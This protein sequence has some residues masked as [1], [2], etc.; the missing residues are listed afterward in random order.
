MS[1]LDHIGKY[2]NCSP[3]LPTNYFIFC[4]FCSSGETFWS[5]RTAKIRWN[6]RGLITDQL[7]NTSCAK[8]VCNTFP[9]IISEV[10]KYFEGQKYLNSLLSPKLEDSVRL[11]QRVYKYTSTSK[12]HT[13]NATNN[14]LT[15]F[16]NFNNF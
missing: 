11:F 15:S 13:N 1:A 9:I 16:K 6:R 14:F 10:K 4:I 8:T 2:T 3:K 12:Q 7:C 5:K